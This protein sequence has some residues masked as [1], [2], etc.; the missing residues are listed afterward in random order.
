MVEG[1]E[2]PPLEQSGGALV[3]VREALAGEQMP[4]SL[5]QGQLCGLSGHGALAGGI[6]NSVLALAG[7]AKIGKEND[8]DLAQR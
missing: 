6:E 7:D 4:I 8:A 3:V 1:A 5:V 2:R